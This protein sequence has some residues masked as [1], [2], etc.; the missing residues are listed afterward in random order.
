MQGHN[1]THSTQ[2]EQDSFFRKRQRTRGA[3]RAIAGVLAS[4]LL[5]FSIGSAAAQDYGP[6]PP[7][8]D[9]GYGAQ[10]SNYQPQGPDQLDQLVAPIA[11]Y[12]DSLVAQVLAAAT[13]PAQVASAEQLVQQSGN[14][15]PD[16][17]AQIA[18][19]QPWDPSVKALVAFPQVLNDMNRN[20]DWT[21]TLGNAYFNQPQDV[22]SAVQVM[23]Q[24]AYSAGTL[25]PTPQL[26]VEYAPSAIVIEPVN[27]NVVYVPYYNPWAVYGAP[28]P[29]YGHYYYGGPPRGVVFATGLALGFGVGLAIGAFTHFSWGYHSWAPN[30]GARTIV[31]NH[32]TYIS[33]SVTVINHGNYG[34]FDRAPAARA[35]NQQQAARF[36][37]V[38][39]R[40]T[41][42]NVTVNRGGN[43]F[44]NGG[45]SYNRTGGSTFNN[46]GN[47]YN[48]G[49]A[50]YNNGG[51]SFNRGTATSPA[52]TGGSF[53]RG[54]QQP[55][56]GNSNSS[57]NRGTQQPAY[58]G[59]NSNFNHG[60][61]QPAYNGGGF[62]RGAQPAPAARPQAAPGGQSYGAS[63]GGSR[64]QPQAQPQHS[65]PQQQSH[66]N[67]SSHE[68]H[69][70]G[71]G[72]DDHHR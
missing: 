42:N 30:W 6:P 20:M 9:S 70:G 14:Y 36:S 17:L 57:F 28:I 61:Q 39:N 45:N 40:T 71:G 58:N 46:G 60:A 21:T 72:H 4:T 67:T 34:A 7:P 69:G 13:Y 56:Y 48:R 18:N 55:T 31:Y 43:T 49:G 32:N 11:L 59:G 22:L 10:A 37:N 35:F 3:Q 65:A 2:R 54:A 19:T 52:N 50:A 47:T 25:R 66:A 41:I 26:A 29:V 16:Q 12:P 68:S 51:S 1:N 23:R 63:G 53:S 5:P 44:N 62:N 24:R 33:R 8:P 15:P 64:P 38:S 27:P